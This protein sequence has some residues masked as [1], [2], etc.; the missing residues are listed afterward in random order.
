MPVEFTRDRYSPIRVFISYAHQDRELMQGLVGCLYRSRFEVFSDLELLPGDVFDERRAEWLEDAQIVLLLVSEHYLASSAVEIEVAMILKRRQHGQVAVVPVLLT[1]VDWH[2]A[3]YANLQ[4][5]PQ[6]RRPVADWPRPVDAF[7]S[8]ADSLIK[9]V[10]SRT[11]HTHSTVFT[12]VF[13]RLGLWDDS[14]TSKPDYNSSRGPF[15]ILWLIYSSC[16]LFGSVLFLG[17]YSTHP[18]VAAN[19][20]GQAQ[21]STTEFLFNSMVVGVAAMSIV[22][23]GRRLFRIR[24]AFHRD[25]L[26]AWLDRPAMTDLYARVRTGRIS[27]MFDLPA[28]MLAGQL[29]A[30]AEQALEEQASTGRPSPLVQGMAA[31]GEPSVRGR[32]PKASEETSETGQDSRTSLAL[33]IQR[34]L[35]HFQ[36]ATAADWKRYLLL[37]SIILSMIL[38]TLGL[39]LFQAGSFIPGLK[40]QPITF[41]DRLGNLT[42]L[43]AC[44]ILVGLFGGFL[45]SIARDVVAIIEKLRR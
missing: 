25:A 1:G 18:A 39:Q 22:Q 8:I 9:L 24:G 27:D 43:M 38:F 17:W 13:T 5:L 35:D 41:P 32:Q 33:A 7:H 19:A 42:A 28:E 31:G 2:S 6:G 40:A 14:I 26:N 45:G 10:E 15:K 3:P 44:A 12:R 34:N 37:T 23:I 30:V 16:L 36:I 21:S 11:P 29:S 20:P 4:A